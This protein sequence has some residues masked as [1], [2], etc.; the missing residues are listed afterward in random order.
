MQMRRKCL[1]CNNFIKQYRWK[2]VAELWTETAIQ[3]VQK[4][5]FIYV[6]HQHT[7]LGNVHNI[8]LHKQV[9]SSNSRKTGTRERSQRPE[10]DSLGA[11]AKRVGQLGT[12]KSVWDNGLYAAGVI[13]GVTVDFLVDSGSTASLLSQQSFDKIGG[14]GITGLDQRWVIMQGVDANN[15]T[16]FGSAEISISFGGSQMRH[17][18]IVCDIIPEG[19]LGQDFSLK[20]IKSW[21]LGVPSLTTRQYTKIRLEIGG[22]SGSLLCFC[23]GQNTYSVAYSQLCP[24]ENS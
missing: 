13:Q 17:T 11:D 12:T 7:S 1:H 15:I 10:K 6:N 5:H 22:D 23:T 14:E 4:L 24:C 9:L 18:V 21:D 2:C 20:H 19:I 3:S 8:G 16:V